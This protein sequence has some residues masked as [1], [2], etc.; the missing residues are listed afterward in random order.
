MDEGNPLSVHCHAASDHLKGFPERVPKNTLLIL[1]SN[2]EVGM[3]DL[4]IKFECKA[5]EVLELTKCLATQPVKGDIN[6]C[7]SK[8]GNDG[9]VLVDIKGKVK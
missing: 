5:N 8:L 9:L 3:T 4:N 2:K 6:V 1:D 7:I